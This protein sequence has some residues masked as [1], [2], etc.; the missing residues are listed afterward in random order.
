MIFVFS[1]ISAGIKDS[2]PR[3]R[4]AAVVG[5]GKVWK[6]SPSV[7]EENGMVDVLYTMVRDPDPHVLTFAIQ[8]I[9]VILS[10][11]GGIVINSTMANYLIS[12]LFS[13][14]DILIIVNTCLYL[15]V[16]LKINFQYLHKY[17]NYN[18]IS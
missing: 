2:N 12:R 6:H 14:I 16:Y 5:C 13:F 7:I 8:T 1:A 9:N 17:S 3:V 18:L 11:E 4:K 10:K 15:Y